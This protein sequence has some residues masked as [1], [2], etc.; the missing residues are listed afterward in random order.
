QP[1]DVLLC[2]VVVRLYVS[3]CRRRTSHLLGHDLHVPGPALLSVGVGVIRGA[4][5]LLT[6]RLHGFI[7]LVQHRL[8][9]L[10]RPSEQGDRSIECLVGS[11]YLHVWFPLLLLI[12]ARRR[13]SRRPCPSSARPRRRR[14]S[15]AQET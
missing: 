6:K 5:P 9:V 13:C 10:V 12:T 14:V 3:E 7:E 15:A 2:G 4:G 1:H 11:S 8:E